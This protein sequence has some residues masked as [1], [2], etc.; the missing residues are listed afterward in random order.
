MMHSTYVPL[1]WSRNKGP[2]KG[3]MSFPCTPCISCPVMLSRDL[4]YHRYGNPVDIINEDRENMHPESL[5]YP[6]V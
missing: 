2:E 3:P 1:S 6:I 4:R 5:G